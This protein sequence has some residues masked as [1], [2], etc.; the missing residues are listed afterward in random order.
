MFRT[1]LACLF[2]TLIS[3]NIL[4][5]FSVLEAALISCWCVALLQVGLGATSAAECTVAADDCYEPPA[6]F[7][8]A[9]SEP[10][11]GRWDSAAIYTGAF[12]ATGG[13]GHD[14]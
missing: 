5:S 1:I 9:S 6:G 14:T 13:V 2:I 3:L 12:E 11:A 10:A 8:A 7:G 4:P